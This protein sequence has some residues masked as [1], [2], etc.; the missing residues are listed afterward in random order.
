MV[1][2]LVHAAA[3]GM[4]L[5]LCHSGPSRWALFVLGTN[6]ADEKAALARQHGCDYPIVYGREDAV[7]EVSKINGWGH[8]DGRVR[9]G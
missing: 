2:V 4:G 7:S 3:G 5:I 8:G 6:S 1:V 9:C